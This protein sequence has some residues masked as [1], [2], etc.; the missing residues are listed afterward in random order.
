MC[1]A[2]NPV[3]EQT[4]A[5]MLGASERA[6][7]RCFGTRVGACEAVTLRRGAGGG[8]T[9]GNDEKGRR[10]SNRRHARLL[11]KRVQP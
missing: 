7:L 3:T 2:K 6:G 9:S 4:L 5:R 8:E 10:M 1:E 11:Q